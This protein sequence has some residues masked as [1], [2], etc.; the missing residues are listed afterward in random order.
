MIT[1]SKREI[2][3]GAPAGARFASWTIPAVHLLAWVGWA[4]AQDTQQS[5]TGET[6]TTQTSIEYTTPSRTVQSQY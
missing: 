2:R 3:I 4:Q 5:S 1:R 6:T